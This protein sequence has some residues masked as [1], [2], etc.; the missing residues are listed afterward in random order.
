MMVVLDDRAR[1]RRCAPSAGPAPNKKERIVNLLD[2][3]AA[4]DGERRAADVQPLVGSWQ[5]QAPQAYQSAGVLPDVGGLAGWMAGQMA[6][7][8][9]LIMYRQP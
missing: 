7:G 8:G 6:S 1:A 3:I 2:R 9:G 5:Q 4:A